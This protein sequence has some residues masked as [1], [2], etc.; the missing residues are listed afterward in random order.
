MLLTYTHVQLYIYSL[1]SRSHSEP[2][3][4]LSDII[5]LLSLFTNIVRKHRLTHMKLPSFN[6]DWRLNPS[7]NGTMLDLKKMG[8]YSRIW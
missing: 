1:H 2:V 4:S 6:P 5:V 7:T 3:Y 8:D